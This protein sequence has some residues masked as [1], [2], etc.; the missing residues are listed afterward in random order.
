MNKG[1][2]KILSDLI[3]NG[4]LAHDGKILP[5]ILRNS[6]SEHNKN[7]TDIE[8]LVNFFFN[9]DI[10]IRKKTTT[11]QPK[12]NNK[13]G[14]PYANIA[15]TT[16]NSYCFSNPFTFSSRKADV[17]VQEMIKAF[18]DAL[19]DDNYGEKTSDVEMNSGKCGL[20]YKYIRPATREERLAGK[21]FE[22]SSEL[23]SKKTFCVYA[24]DLM[25]HKILAVTY[26]D[27]TEYDEKGNPTKTYTRYNCWTKYHYWIIDDKDGEYKVVNQVVN[28]NIYR[29]YPLIYKRIPIVEYPRKN[30]RTSDFEI[31]I[32]LINANNEV[33]SSRVDDLQQA[34]DYILS[35]RDIATETKEDIDGIKAHISEGIIS[36]RSIQGA[37]VQPEVKVLN[38]MQNQSQVQTMQDFL[39][40]KIEEALNIP[41]RETRGSS[42]DTGTAVENRAGYRSLENIAGLITSSARIA[43]SESLDIILAICS[44]YDECPFKD[45]TINDIR[46]DDN[47]NKMENLS[48]A[49]TAYATLIGAG[50]NDQTA[51]EITK[52]VS[53][54]MGVAKLNEQANEKKAKEEAK[55]QKQ[56]ETGVD[57][58]TTQNN[59][60]TNSDN[61]DV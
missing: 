23:D 50:M 19:D 49:S 61:A 24:N 35:L 6:I 30:D 8:T 20:G 15:V 3:P 5:T 53:D 31:A 4:D 41:N 55:T 40:H 34:V 21:F 39:G 14:I 22:T 13:V 57:N 26:Y 36:F 52:I 60:G 11:Q 25:K 17:K 28:G 54:A 58:N 59:N 37:T 48:S 18:N 7:K 51:L 29:A 27:Y 43:E 38:T 9:D 16:I 56:Q 42:G 1:R 44:L 46:I 12:I 47:R 45:L 2:I 33:I 10:D 32:D